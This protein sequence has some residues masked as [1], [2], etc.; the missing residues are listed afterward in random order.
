MSQ[1][2]PAGYALAAPVGGGAADRAR[3][4]AG[5]VILLLAIRGGFP[6][7]S[8]LLWTVMPHIGW[9]SARMITSVMSGLET[10][11]AIVAFIFFLIWTHRLISA[12]VERGE[13]PRFSP[14]FAVGSWFI[15]FANIVLP[16]MALTDAWRRVLR[17][18]AGLV[19]GWWLAYI[20][21]ILVDG[22]RGAMTGGGG[23]A[24]QPWLFQTIHWL[25][26]IAAVTAY[27]LWI[28]MVRRISDGL[29]AR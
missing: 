9:R 7:L 12:I 26:L 27:G 23:I 1:I 29:A 28:L 8:K 19:V 4:I 17:S 16:V 10:I 18:G 3:R 2:Q 24:F 15:P 20:F 6:I 13:Q 21:F 22:A 14:G 11:V 25:D 5:T